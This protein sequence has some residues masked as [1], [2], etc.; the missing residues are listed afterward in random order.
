MNTHEFVEKY[1]W[2]SQLQ[3]NAADLDLKLKVN[4]ENSLEPFQIELSNKIIYQSS[5]LANVN[6]FLFA[7]KQG[8]KVNDAGE[9]DE[10]NGDNS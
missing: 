1:D 3:I 5:V 4:I 2:F 8:M 9:T 6:I 7:Y 10:R